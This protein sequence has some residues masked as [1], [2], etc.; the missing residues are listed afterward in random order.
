[1]IAARICP[2]LIISSLFCQSLMSLGSQTLHFIYSC[3]S[4]SWHYY[5]LWHFV[6]PSEMNTASER[7]YTKELCSICFS[8]KINRTQLQSSI[9][10]YVLHSTFRINCLTQIITSPQLLNRSQA[11]AS[12]TEHLVLHLYF[13]SHSSS[14]S[15]SLHCSSRIFYLLIYHLISLLTNPHQLDAILL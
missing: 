8:F 14:L 1:M 10:T 6:A 13:L 15:T 5:T 3:L 4:Q 11:Y 9:S 7:E 2:L 12:L